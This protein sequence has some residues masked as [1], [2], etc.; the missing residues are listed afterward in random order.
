MRRGHR[1]RKQRRKRHR[2]HSKRDAYARTLPPTSGRLDTAA[3]ARAIEASVPLIPVPRIPPKPTTSH[4]LACASGKL[5]QSRSLAS[6]A[7]IGM[8]LVSSGE[9]IMQI[10]RCRRVLHGVALRQFSCGA[11]S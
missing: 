5:L 7:H 6:L 10:E 8:T 4:K 1:Y 2:W 9:S 11:P 3:N